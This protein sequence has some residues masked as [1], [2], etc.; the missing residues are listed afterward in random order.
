VFVTPAPAATSRPA[1]TAPAAKPTVA[2]PKPT[3]AAPKPTTVPIF[4]NP[5]GPTPVSKPNTTR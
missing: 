5:I 2:A 3:V 1:N 4:G